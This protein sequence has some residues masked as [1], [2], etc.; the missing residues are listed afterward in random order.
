MHAFQSIADAPPSCSGAQ[1]LSP[2]SGYFAV[3]GLLKSNAA[4]RI[5]AAKITPQD[6]L[7]T[8]L[9]NLAGA[10][11]AATFGAGATAAVM[12]FA[13][14]HNYFGSMDILVA[15]AAVSV[16]SAGTPSQHFM[17][18]DLLS[19]S[20][21]FAVGVLIPLALL[22]I[23]TQRSTS[24][25]EALPSKPQRLLARIAEKDA[26]AGARAR[27]AAAAAIESAENAFYE[28]SW[29]R[30]MGSELWCVDTVPVRA[31]G[32]GAM[33]CLQVEKDGRLEWVCV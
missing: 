3:S 15:A 33:T 23:A 10:T 4:E 6:R 9:G 26:A 29:V 16:T 24:T 27:A 14:Q 19:S 8:T 25:A 17:I 31:D 7:K 20:N 18:T 28:G 21:T 13:L 30:G 1:A 22:N 12:P 5:K 11:V 32:S 2:A